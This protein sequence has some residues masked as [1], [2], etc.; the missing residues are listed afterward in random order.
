MSG[1]RQPL[2]VLPSKIARQPPCFIVGFGDCAGA[3]GCKQSSAQQAAAP[4]LII[5]FILSLITARVYENAGVSFRQTGAWI[6]AACPVGVSLPVF[7]SILNTTTLSV[8]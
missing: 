4:S 8:F 2:S 5:N 6:S 7:A 3:G 1:A